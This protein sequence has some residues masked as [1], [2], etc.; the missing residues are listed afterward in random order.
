MNQ[1]DSGYQEFSAKGADGR[2]HT[3]DAPPDAL[4]DPSPYRTRCGQ[5]VFEVYN[6]RIEV[7][8][9]ACADR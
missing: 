6:T 5:P 8:C 3:V 7:T 4:I 1:R 2:V 9:P